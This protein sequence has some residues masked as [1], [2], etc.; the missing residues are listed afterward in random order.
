MQ[1][2]LLVN[3]R[4]RAKGRKTRTAAQRAAT[5]R[6]VAFNRARNSPTTKRAL[7][8]R[9]IARAR[10][11]AGYFPN[12]A[13]RR[14]SRVGGIA[15]TVRRYKRNPSTAPGANI[16]NMLMTS[17]QGAGGAIAVNTILNYIPLPD[18]LKTGNMKYLV[19]GAAAI[20]LGIAGRR[21]LPARV[22]TNMAI[23]S[24]T[25][26]MHDAIREVAGNLIPGVTLGGV[27]YY[28]GGYPVTA[29]PAALSAPAP[30]R[31]RAMAGIGMY[32]E[33]VGISL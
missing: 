14:R 27:G 5:K 1:E 16:T 2:L 4:G 15:R 9:V 19:R 10:P 28:T 17:L 23:G 11:V 31:G 33:S 8:R 3:P 29:A 22:A 12:P 25:V 18:M 21:V 6:L 7:K 26:T 30:A 13:K 32:Q 20:M 24:L